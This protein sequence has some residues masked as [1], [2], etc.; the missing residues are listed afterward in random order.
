MPDEDPRLTY[1]LFNKRVMDKLSDPPKFIELIAV[2]YDFIAKEAGCK[3]VMSPRR[4]LEA[5]ILWQADLTRTLNEGISKPTKKLDHFKQAAFLAFWLRRLNPINDTKLVDEDNPVPVHLMNDQRVQFYRYGNE[6]AALLIGFQI[7][8]VHESARAFPKGGD[9]R[10]LHGARR[11]EYLRR[12]RFPNE[13]LKDYAM[14]LKHKSMSPH[15]L[16]LMYRS[17]FAT[18]NGHVEASG[19]PA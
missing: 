4:L 16:Y 7:C 19:T 18:L 3:T 17:L 10:N 1:S 9:V 6:I 15:S 2:N 5:H 13:L 8:L 12:V 11:I 14:I